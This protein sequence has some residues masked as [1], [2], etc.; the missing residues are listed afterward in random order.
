VR[1]NFPD[2]CGGI[3]TDPNRHRWCRPGSESV[4]TSL[5]STVGLRLLGSYVRLFYGAD[6]RNFPDQYGGIAT[7]LSTSSIHWTHLLSRNFPDQYGGIATACSAGASR[8]SAASL[9]TSLISTVG[10]R[11]LCTASP[12]SHA[13]PHAH[14]RNFPDQ[15]GGIATS[16]CLAYIGPSQRVETLELP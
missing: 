12:P 14:C 9:G 7:F 3:A 10:L 6:S 15:Y 16:Q 13:H 8:S 11:L 4:G 1:P 2:Q 5:I